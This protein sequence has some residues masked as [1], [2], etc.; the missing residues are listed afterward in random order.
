M[1][2]TVVFEVQ[3]FKLDYYKMMIELD[4]EEN[5]YLE[6]CRHFREVYQTPMVQNDP[7]KLE[8][9]MSSFRRG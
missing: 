5:N 4:Q 7:L 3:Q 9:V 1:G 6:I 2:I 8:E